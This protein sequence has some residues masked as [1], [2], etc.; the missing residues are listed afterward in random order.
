[1]SQHTTQLGYDSENQLIIE[2]SQTDITALKANKITEFLRQP[3]DWNYVLETAQRNCVLPLVSWNLTRKFDSFL[4][5]EIKNRLDAYFQNQTRNNMF[6]TA[7][8]IEIIKL[9]NSNDIPVLPFKGPVLTMQFYENIALKTET[10]VSGIS[11]K[12]GKPGTI[13]G[14]PLSIFSIATISSEI[15]GCPRL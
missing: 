14:M 4:S 5:P 3:L 9:F 6:L 11:L 13:E 7:K 2:C 15:T 8:L 1:M 12:L 10:A